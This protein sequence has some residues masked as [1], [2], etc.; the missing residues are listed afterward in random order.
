MPPLDPNCFYSS[1]AQSAAAI[2]GLMGGI[3]ATRLEDQITTSS[4]Q[5]LK[6]IHREGVKSF[7][8]NSPLDPPDRASKAQSTS[9]P[10][11]GS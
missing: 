4:E 1:L 2:V 6:A 8:D 5:K 10:S 11:E 9:R 3:F 7:V